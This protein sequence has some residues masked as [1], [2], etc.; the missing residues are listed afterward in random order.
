MVK[1]I[2]IIIVAAIFQLIAQQSVIGY[3]SNSGKDPT[4]S[5]VRALTHMNF[6]FLNPDGDTGA[7]ILEFNERRMKKLISYAKL[8]N[9]K[10]LI[11]FGGGRAVFSKELLE[12]NTNR[13]NF[14]SNMVQFVE[15]NKLDGIDCDWEPDW[16]K[17]G[18]TFKGEQL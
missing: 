4:A 8:Y 2:A 12:N 16:D 15:D 13:H 11:T 14:I 9:V 5:Q 18:N 7:L 1:K 10:A 6:C 17:H 3:I